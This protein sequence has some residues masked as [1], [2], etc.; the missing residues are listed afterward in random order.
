MKSVA[1]SDDGEVIVSSS[2]D[3]QAMVWRKSRLGWEPLPLRWHRK[4]GVPTCVLNKEG[5]I[6]AGWDGF[7]SEWSLNGFLKRLLD[8]RSLLREDTME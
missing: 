5:V 4:P 2:Y 7:V 3:A 6:L 8:V 1:A